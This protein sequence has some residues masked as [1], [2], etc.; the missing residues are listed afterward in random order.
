MGQFLTDYQAIIRQ[1]GGVLIIGF[2]LYLLGVFKIPFLMR[3]RR[4]HFNTRQ[5][6][7]LGSFLIGAAFA[8]GWTP[9]VGPVLATM[10]M[11]ASTTETL[12]DGVTL[13]GFYS[14]GLGLPLFLASLGLDRFLGCMKGA[15]RYLN[16]ASVANGIVL[17]A[18]GAIL[19]TNSLS[20]LTALFEQHGIGWY[21]GLDSGS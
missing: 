21:F 20:L 9:C 16:S 19:Y 14:F 5:A 2:G 10:L 11:Y 7:Y 12:L 15:R 13:L 1:T 18:F 6:G 17:I 3:E 4:L 8:A